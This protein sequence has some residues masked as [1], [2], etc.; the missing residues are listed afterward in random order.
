MRCHDTILHTCCGRIR[1]ITHIASDLTGLHCLYHGFFIYQ[2][3][4]CIIQKDHSILHLCDGLFI[5]HLFGTLQ[6]RY[7]NGDIITFPINIIHIGNMCDLSGQ[8]PGRING[9][10]WIIAIYF[11][12][13]MDCGIGYQNTDRSQTDDTQLFTLYFASGKILLFFF[14]QFGNVFITAFCFYPVDTI[15]QISGC[16]Q[17]PCND[18]LFHTICIG[19]WSIKDYNPLLCTTL[20]GNIVHSG[21]GSGD[22]CQLI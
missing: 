20:Q 1:E 18:R 10:I 3:I 5:D 14:C 7:M 15:C 22:C 12:S 11:H 21:S 6:K 9:Y 19:S 17:K 13:K 2:K 4:S 16:Q 8:V